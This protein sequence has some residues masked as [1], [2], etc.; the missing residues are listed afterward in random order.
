M[1]LMDPVEVLMSTLLNLDVGF[2]RF[3]YPKNWFPVQLLQPYLAPLAH[4]L[5]SSSF[6]SSAS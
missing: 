1:G 6:V 2:V 4:L 3:V 5:D